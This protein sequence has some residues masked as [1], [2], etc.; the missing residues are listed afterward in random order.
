MA[1]WD[2]ASRK[3]PFSKTGTTASKPPQTP[4]APASWR[5][6][7]L[8][9]NRCWT[10][11]TETKLSTL[12]RI[13]TMADD[14]ALFT[15]ARRVLNRA[16]GNRLQRFFSWR[17]YTRVR[18]SQFHFLFNNSDRVKTFPCAALALA[19]GNNNHHPLPTD[20]ICQGYEFTAQH[21]EVDIHMQIMAE[22]IL[23]GIRRPGLGRGQ[24]T[25]LGGIPKL[26]APPGLRK[27]ALVSGWGFHAGPGP[28]RGQ[29]GRLAVDGRGLGAAVCAR[30]VGVG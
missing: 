9:V 26:K 10:S 1:F 22:T 15:E 28:L 16:Q 23:Q 3:K 24:R 7:Y 29:D 21:S 30:V 11:I 25:V 2:W 5:E 20:M 12:S 18:L 13:D 4:P 19:L 8:C 6:A 27:Q 14:C 17:S